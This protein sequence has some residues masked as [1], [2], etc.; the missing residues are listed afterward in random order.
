MNIA[1]VGGVSPLRQGLIEVE[2]PEDAVVDHGFVS[3]T[4]EQGKDIHAKHDD[5]SST[6]AY[7][8]DEESAAIFDKEMGLEDDFDWNNIY[9]RQQFQES[10]FKSDAVSPDGATSIAQIMPDTFADGLKKGYVPEGTK[11]EDLATDD[12]LAIQFQ[13]SYMEDLMSR[14]WNKGTEEV[15]IAKALAAYNMGPTGLV[16]YLTE[17]KAAGVDIYNSLDWIEGL[18]KETK[19]YVS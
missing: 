16:N 17:Q 19:N 4:D 2:V 18:N 14:S 12:A 11:Y 9:T 6:G 5:R 3:W 13:K 8:F 7:V 10:R 1:R 15:K